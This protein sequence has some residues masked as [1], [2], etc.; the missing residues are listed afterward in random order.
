[1]KRIVKS[2]M[3]PV[4][5][6]LLEILSSFENII[7]KY[8]RKPLYSPLF[9]IGA[10][11]SGT[12]LS[13]QLLA[14]NFNTCYI[15]NVMEKYNKFA[16]ALSYGQAIINGCN[17][18]GN[19]SSVYGETVG[20]NAPSQGRRFWDNFFKTGEQNYIGNDEIDAGTL[21]KLRN[22]VLGLQ[23]IFGRPFI[24][25]ALSL[26]VRLLPLN[27]ALP[28]SLFMCIHRSRVDVVRSM[29]KGWNEYEGG[30]NEWFSVKPLEYKYINSE[31]LLAKVCGQVYY[32]EKD[33]M[34]DL[35]IIG[36]GKCIHVTYDDICENPG[37]ILN[38]LEEFY[39]NNCCLGRLERT[40]DPPEKFTRSKVANI[41]KEEVR[42]IEE[43]F[44]YL[45]G[46]D[47]K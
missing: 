13:Y 32:I 22:S 2:T 6:A 25:K 17:P 19:Y 29:M 9:I 47:D 31:D 26:G 40:N 14:N 43:N 16:C 12:T 21:K 7:L 4:C 30:N 34:R 35:S 20:W 28:E 46:C 41:S 24:N 18:P 8:D 27:E 44:A 3:R 10:P 33:I 38:K 39:N 11:R 45:E 42:M 15:N 1:M 36:D 37:V 23:N 5:N